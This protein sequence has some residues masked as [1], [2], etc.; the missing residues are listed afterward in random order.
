MCFLG[1]EW[2]FFVLFC[3]VLFCFVLFYCWYTIC[4]EVEASGIWGDPQDVCMYPR[5]MVIGM[6]AWKLQSLLPLMG[7]ELLEG[8]A[9]P[10]IF[11]IYGCIF[12]VESTSIIHCP[13]LSAKSGLM[14]PL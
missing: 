12:S 7:C 11:W 8:W 4:L 10:S 2:V 1:G 6:H 3:F 13:H 5:V 9:A 14:P